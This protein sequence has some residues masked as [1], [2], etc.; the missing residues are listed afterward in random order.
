MEPRHGGYR[1]GGLW[2]AAGIS[3]GAVVVGSGW[4][5]FGM[6]EFDERCSQGLIE[7]PGRLL[8]VRDQAFP[9]ATICEFERGEVSSIGG[10]GLLSVLLWGSLMVLVI[11]LFVALIAECFEPRLGSDLVAPMSRV[12]KLRRTAAAFFVTGSGFLMFYA[13]AG[14]KLFAGPSSVCSAGADWGFHPP[15]TLE[16]SFF[17]PQATCQYASGENWKIN[18]DWVASLAVELAVPAL[19]AGVGFVLAWRRWR[20]ERRTTRL[21]SVSAAPPEATA[22]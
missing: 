16:Y 11:C 14:W 17:P 15:R 2:V 8:R 18:P 4:A 22:P 19:I 6:I 13:W 21:G 7:G 20:S 3:L 10:S 5:E 12:E 1:T 9:P